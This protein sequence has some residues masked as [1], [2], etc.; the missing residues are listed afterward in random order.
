[1]NKYIVPLFAWLIVMMIAGCDDTGRVIQG[2]V[3]AYDKNAMQVTFIED[4]TLVQGKPEYTGLPPVVFK[5]PEDA[6]E[7]G[8]DPDPGLRMKLD[9]EN[10]QITIFDAVTQRFRDIPYVLIEKKD[11][12]DKNDPLVKGKAYPI[13]DRDA[14]TIQIF[15]K[16]QKILVTFTL[17]QEY[18]ALADMTWASGDEVR[19]YYKEDKKALR[20]MNI[21][22]T[23]IFKK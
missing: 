7:M 9:V 10:N 16:R 21:T 14:K 23:D 15:S 22:K 20:M 2:R 1:M 13:I 11:I 19:I 12:I 3:I 8:A 6:N 4:K 17:P 18:F 5:I